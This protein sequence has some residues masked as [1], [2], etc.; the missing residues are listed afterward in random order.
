[1]VWRGVCGDG[2]GPRVLTLCKNPRMR[3]SDVRVRWAAIGAAVAVTLGAGGLVGAGATSSSSSADATLV[4][5]SPVRILDTRP[6]DRVGD[7]TDGASITVQVTGEVAT[8][9]QGTKQ[10]VP[11]G[12]SAVVGNLTVVD[13]QANEYGGFAT[14]YPCD[15][16]RPDASNLNFVSGVTVANSVAVP[17]SAVGT[18]CV[19]LYGTAHVLLDV[20]GYYSTDRLAELTA[21]PLA[22]VDCPETASLVRTDG[23]WVCTPTPGYELVEDANGRRFTSVNGAVE[24]DGELFS[25]G[26]PDGFYASWFGW[27]PGSWLTPV[28]YPTAGCTG[29]GF[30]LTD[31][32]VPT[33]D[34]D[35]V[36][37]GTSFVAGSWGDQVWGRV[38]YERG[39]TT[40]Q[41]WRLDESSTITDADVV[42][43]REDDACDPVQS[44][45]TWSGAVAYELEWL[46][47]PPTA[48]FEAP[49]SKVFGS[50][51][52]NVCVAEVEVDADVAARAC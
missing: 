2:S 8:V 18:V 32:D 36:F 16:T 24:I 1:M 9:G 39:S 44:Q 19:Y 22:G 51:G 40:L 49:F 35:T 5:V 12:A 37:E 47:E 46:G 38:G 30:M 14:M 7:L 29:P 52:G 42:S 34:P 15:A 48:Q 17:L 21:A 26:A 50:A 41:Y 23:E 20:S 10:V 4:P 3:L 28:Y 43:V 13:T 31:P 33:V 45:P 27:T 11:A 25:F 6:G